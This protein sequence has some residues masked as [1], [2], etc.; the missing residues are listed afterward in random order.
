MDDHYDNLARLY[1]S[2]Y[3]SQRNDIGFYCAQA[4][5]AGGR[6]LELACGTG[7]IYLRLLRARVDAYG[8]DSSKSMLS[9]L[10]KKAA[11]GNLAAKVK[12][13]D[14]RSFSYPFRFSL[15]IIPFRAFL[16]LLSSEDQLAALRC[17]R[18]H[19]APG[20]RLILNFFVPSPRFI[21]EN[22]WKW[23]S[24]E[25]GGNERLC[26]RSKTTFSDEINQVVRVDMRVLRNG[27][28]MGRGAFRIALI[29]KQEFE[30]LLRQAGFS[31][32]KVYGGFKKKRLV[33]SKQEMVWAVEK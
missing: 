5:K 13:S 7:R 3:L 4:R 6:V 17:I 33:S 32:W 21:S 30:L 16:H 26:V 8:L 19:L 28:Q 23:T 1:D 20:G 12:Q 2:I 9:V 31:R 24:R 10:R 18:R 15:I 25:V 29:H 14:M 22:Y 11:E 27:R